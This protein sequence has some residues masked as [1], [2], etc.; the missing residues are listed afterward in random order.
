MN[1]DRGEGGRELHSSPPKPIRLSRDSPLRA[2]INGLS[3][4]LEKLAVLYFG[5]FHLLLLEK[6]ITSLDQTLLSAVTCLLPS[7]CLS[8]IEQW[9]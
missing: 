9:P 1:D 2:G 3:A 6:A 8:I 7:P 4:T 5:M